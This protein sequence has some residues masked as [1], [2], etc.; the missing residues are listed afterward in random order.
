MTAFTTPADDRIEAD[1]NKRL[2]ALDV[3]VTLWREHRG[4]ATVYL[5]TFA[6]GTRRK[7]VEQDH[8]YFDEN[9]IVE[10]ARR[11]KTALGNIQAAHRWVLDPEEAD[12]MP[13]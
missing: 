11:W 9:E 12:F 10:Q 8:P 7:L 4:E 6:H 13:E 2:I 5:L 3:R 1:I